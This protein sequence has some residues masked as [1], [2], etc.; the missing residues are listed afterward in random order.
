[1]TYSAVLNVTRDSVVSVYIKVER[2]CTTVV[3]PGF[4]IVSNVD[5]C[6]VKL[7]VG[8]CLVRTRSVN[9]VYSLR[10]SVA[11]TASPIP[12]MQTPLGMISPRLVWMKPMWFASLDHL[13]L[14]TAQNVPFANARMDMFAAQ[15]IHSAFRNCEAKDGEFQEALD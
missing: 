14:S 4:K 15:W 3:T 6:R 12:A 1:M 8:P 7:T 5:V 10:T 9:S 13:G 2:F 11:R